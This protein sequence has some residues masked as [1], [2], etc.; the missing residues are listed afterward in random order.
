MLPEK[1]FVTH[2]H[3]GTRLHV[4]CPACILSHRYKVQVAPTLKA[5]LP[6]NKERTRLLMLDIKRIFFPNYRKP[7]YSIKA[8]L[9]LLV[10]TFAIGTACATPTNTVSS[11]SWDAYSDPSAVGFF[12]Y[13]RD[14]SQA[15]SQYSNTQRFSITGTTLTTETLSAFLPA[16]HQPNLCF[17][18]TAVDAASNESQFSN[19]VCGFTGFSSPN[20]LTIK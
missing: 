5:A 13:W 14:K 2:T 1:T 4:G 20:H 16:T 19:E 10:F 15:A 7:W 11:L 17:V 8:A 12:V 18:L 9:C 3:E 6:F